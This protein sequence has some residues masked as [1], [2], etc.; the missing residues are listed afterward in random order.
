M[1]LGQLEIYHCIRAI[2][3]KFDPYLYSTNQYFININA[4]FSF[5]DRL[6]TKIKY[7]YISHAYVF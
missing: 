6:L 3:P 1:I 7:L 5:L 4:V 2:N